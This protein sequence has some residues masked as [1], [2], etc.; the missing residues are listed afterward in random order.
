MQP[1]CMD[2][3][4]FLRRALAALLLAACVLAGQSGVATHALGHALEDLSAPARA[5]QATGDDPGAGD[6][7][8]E[9]GERTECPLHALYTQL[10]SMAVGALPALV[11]QP[12]VHEKTVFTDAQA[13]TAPRVAFRSRAPPRLPA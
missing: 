12:A 5:A 8:E 10:A 4:G 6:C 13:F 7:D 1:D 2:R 9:E 11:T 3:P